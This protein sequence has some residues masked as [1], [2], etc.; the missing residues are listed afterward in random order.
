MLVNINT[1]NYRVTYQ[2]L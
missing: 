1:S 2:K